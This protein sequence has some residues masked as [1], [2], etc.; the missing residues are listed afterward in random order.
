M[1]AEELKAAFEELISKLRKAGLND[2]ADNA[3]LFEMYFN[4]PAFKAK[5]EDYIF[6]LTYN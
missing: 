5:F 4:D 1:T 3:R 6:A 2:K